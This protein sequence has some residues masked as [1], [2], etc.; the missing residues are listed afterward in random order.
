[1]A[2]KVGYV[3]LFAKYFADKLLDY[4]NGAANDGPNI[5]EPVIAFIFTAEGFKALKRSV[6][7]HHLISLNR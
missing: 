6:S 3:L 7:T 1:M 5:A 2:G 4:G